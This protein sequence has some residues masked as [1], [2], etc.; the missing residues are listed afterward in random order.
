MRKIYDKLN[1]HEYLSYYD[2]AK[3]MFIHTN[4]QVKTKF[5][6]IDTRMCADLLHNYLE[7]RYD[8]KQYCLN[9]LKNAYSDCIELKENNM[10][11]TFLVDLYNLYVLN[12]LFHELLHFQQVKLL[13][14][15][16][17]CKLKI[18][19][20]SLK[21]SCVSLRM[22]SENHDLYYFEYDALINSFK[23][24]LDIIKNKCKNFDSNAV[25]E[26]NRIVSGMILHSY[27]NTYYHDDVSEIYDM[28]TSPISYSKFSCSHIDNIHAKKKLFFCIEKLEDKSIT[29]YT[30]L[31]NGCDISSKTERLLYDF[32][33]RNYSTENIL[34]DIK[35]MNKKKVKVK[36][37]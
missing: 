23:L 32:C 12:D 34:N 26:Y 29:E 22:Y 7:V 20:E 8:Y 30:R 35:N 5:L 14:K 10:D 16:S 17:T 21:F 36:I 1:N 33:I 27:G 6:N 18:I 19:K 3:F 4:G 2:I 15:K 37:K 13:D 31:I 28:F 11:S 25:I 9:Y 24:T